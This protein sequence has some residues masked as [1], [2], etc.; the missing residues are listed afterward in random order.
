MDG[1][2]L[3]NIEHPRALLAAPGELVVPHGFAPCPELLGLRT[4]DVSFAS[5]A[6]PMPET[7]LALWPRLRMLHHAPGW[8][9]FDAPLESGTPIALIGHGERHLR[10]LI[11]SCPARVA[12][13]AGRR[14]DALVPRVRSVHIDGD[15]EQLTVTWGHTSKYHP[16]RAP[17]WIE[18][19]AA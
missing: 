1:A 19:E 7:V 15:R 13:R 2:L 4:T 12:V 11:P 17:Q 6:R 18:L 14:P 5:D 10:V 9:V 8:L 16:R 3:P